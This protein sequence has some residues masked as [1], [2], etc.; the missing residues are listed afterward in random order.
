[1]DGL[2]GIEELFSISIDAL[3][4]DEVILTDTLGNIDELILMDALG[5]IEEL[6]LMDALG[7][8]DELISIEALGDTML[9]KIISKQKPMLKNEMVSLNKQETKKTRKIKKASNTCF[10]AI[11]LETSLA[12]TSVAIVKI[13]TPS[14]VQAWITF[15]VESYI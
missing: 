2:C 9:V 1:M 5:E 14:V 11:S 8:I 6:I 13:F 4:I 7:D 15:T 3:N 12:I 10:A